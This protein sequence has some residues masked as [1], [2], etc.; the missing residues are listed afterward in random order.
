MGIPSHEPMDK[1][2]QFKE[3][4]QKD[5]IL[6]QEE[7]TRLLDRCEKS[8]QRKGNKYLKDL[9]RFALNTG[10][11]EAEI[12]G[13]KKQAVHVTDR[14]VVA[15]DTKTHKSRNVPLN[16]TALEILGR[17]LKNPRSEY[18]FFSSKGGRITVLTDAFWYAVE[19]S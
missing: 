15:T 4:N 9:V 8:P 5:W 11:R 1:V 13:V 16:D 12:F 10:M 7:E 3:D 14:Y 19:Q 2:K 6:T 18:V 17:R